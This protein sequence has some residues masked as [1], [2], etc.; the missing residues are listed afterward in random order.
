MTMQRTKAA[1]L[2]SLSTILPAC[3]I[4]QT[5]P[6]DRSLRDEVQFAI[7]YSSEANRN[8]AY[9]TVQNGVVYLNGTVDEGYDRWAIERAVNSV[10]GVSAVRNYITID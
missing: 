1:L 5:V 2:L 9:V 6:E 4:N 7:R 10:E 3:A 8:S